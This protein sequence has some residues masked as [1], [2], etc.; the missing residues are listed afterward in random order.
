MS[1]STGFIVGRAQATKAVQE[2]LA[3]AWV[4]EDKTVAGWQNDLTAPQ[5]KELAE[6][7]DRAAGE[8]SPVGGR[9]HGPEPGAGER[10]C[11]SG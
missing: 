2:R 4:W 1:I 11:G 6:R 10:R 7:P 3:G 5:A 9:R 8:G